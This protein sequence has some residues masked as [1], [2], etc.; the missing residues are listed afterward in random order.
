ME[1]KD[2]VIND[3]VLGTLFSFAVL[4]FL[5]YALWVC[6]QEGWLFASILSFFGSVLGS[7]FIAGLFATLTL[8]FI[9]V[10]VWKN[11]L[12]GLLLSLGLFAWHRRNNHNT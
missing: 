4:I 9:K 5:G 10:V 2:N 11:G 6:W 3:D 12:G 8:G 1:S 7:F